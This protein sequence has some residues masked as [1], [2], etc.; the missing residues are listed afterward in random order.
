MGRREAWKEILLSSKHRGT[1]IPTLLA[2]TDEELLAYVDGKEDGIEFRR[3][4][5]KKENK[6]TETES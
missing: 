6:S 5:L 1:L 3:A 2:M 4:Q